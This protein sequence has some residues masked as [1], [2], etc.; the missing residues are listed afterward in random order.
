MT[1][2]FR[3]RG[4]AGARRLVECAAL[5]LA[6][7]GI[8]PLQADEPKPL[9]FERVVID[10]EFPG[11][12]QVE[13][14]DVNGDGRPDVVALGGGTVAWYENPTWI[15]RVVTGPDRTPGVI[16]TATAD[17]DGDGRAEIAIA[18]DFE[19]N[20]PRRGKLGI[21]TAR[22]GFADPWTFTTVADV[23]SIHRVRWAR[24]TGSD[25]PRPSLVVAP[26]FGPGSTPP[27]YEQDQAHLWIFHDLG[28]RG[29]PEGTDPA[30]ARTALQR[31]VWHALGI[32]P[33][34]TAPFGADRLLSADN[35]GIG[36]LIP[37]G[38]GLTR[39]ANPG[40]EDGPSPAV[41]VDLVP[42]ASGPVPNRGCSE[43]HLGRFADGRR[44]LA[45]LEP[46][47]GAKVV[48]YPSRQ[49]A[50][51]E[52]RFLFG[53]PPGP[54]GSP[55]VRKASLPALTFGDPVVLDDTLEAGHA[56]WVADVDGDGT[57]EVFAGHR[58][59][60]PRVAVYRFDGQRWDRT[61]LDRG[62]AAQDLRGG[63]V[64]GDGVPDVVAAG[65]STHNVVLY[66]GVR[67]N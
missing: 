63:D 57:D 30:T 39:G 31:P 64:D 14:A 25:A 32:V 43:I 5:I 48:V 56:L 27:T 49:P 11:A 58:G 16:S 9:R 2:H 7:S 18:Y 36:W 65:G 6:A 24:P 17:L 29:L 19:M 46:W 33:G 41:A 55:H 37:P 20:R 23:P 28:P 47:H 26:L 44:F 50:G 52:G 21:A 4:V 10:A 53:L 3:D 12:Y 61:V 51:P 8:A 66:R 67:G 13:V 60:D 40:D 34:A 54:E 59:K 42:G 15:K 22:P 38:L 1:Q 35:R 62:V 45:T